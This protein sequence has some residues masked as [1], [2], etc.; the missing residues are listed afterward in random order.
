MGVHDQETM[1][2]IL[3]FPIL[4]ILN[5]QKTNHI[6]KYHTSLTNNFALF[7]LTPFPLFTPRSSYIGKF[8]RPTCGGVLYSSACRKY[9]QTWEN[10]HGT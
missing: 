4:Q 1:A 5:W 6:L 7:K 3:I 2:L 8:K 9:Q 10:Y